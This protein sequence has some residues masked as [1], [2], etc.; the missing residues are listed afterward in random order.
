[1]TSRQRSRRGFRNGIHSITQALLRARESP[2]AVPAALGWHALRTH[3]LPRRRGGPAGG[4]DP[5]AHRRALLGLAGLTAVVGTF[6]LMRAA[7]NV[8]AVDAHRNLAAASAVLVGSFGSVA[9]YLYSPLAAM[10]TVPALLLP[11]DV[12]VLA[13]LILK[14]GILTAGVAI[15]T[16]GQQMPDR[17]LVG[18]AIVGF[19]PLLYDLELGNVTVLLLAAIALVAWT[20]DRIATGLPLG[21]IL[22][23]APKP[24][25]IPVLIW[26]IVAHRQAL[27]GATVTAVGA[28]LLGL[29]L[30]GT[31]AYET[32]ISALRA[33][34]YLTSGTVINLSLWSLPPVTA[35]PVALAAVGAFLVALRRGYWPGL[36]AAIC[37]GLLLAPYTLIYGAGLI[38]V[39]ARAA[40]RAS[41]R[42]TLG[43]AITA[44]VALI[45]AFPVWVGLA[46]ALAA[47]CPAQAWPPRPGSMRRS[48]GTRAVP[49]PSL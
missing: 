23:T 1:M 41:P 17:I 39:V 25:V 30:A 7:E 42:A 46:L 49:G 18:I 19:L 16:R 27:V 12:A 47:A 33:P 10:L 4:F 26:M 8:W 11:T 43:L 29:G 45:L 9:G 13:W 37:V 28:T 22:A 21:L 40:V 20:P 5:L 36:L 15:A 2:H 24:Q 35:V 34:E 6:A 3:D 44:P 32:W 14:V 48:A 31:T 38:P